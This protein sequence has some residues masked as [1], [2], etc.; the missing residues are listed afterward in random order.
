MKLTLKGKAIEG[1]AE[2]DGFLK[3]IV[4]DSFSWGARIDDRI[5]EKSKGKSAKNFKGDSIRI[6]KF[7]DGASTNLFG[8]MDTS[9]ESHSAADIDKFKNDNVAVISMAT[10]SNRGP[11]GGGPKKILEMTL[12]G[13]AIRE[14]ATSGSGSGLSMELGEDLQ[15]SF[16][17]MKLDYFPADTTTYT[18]G[19][20][21]SFTMQDKSAR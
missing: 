15:L 10:Y 21:I 9:A 17:E 2:V 13:C 20:A 12:R 3:Y 8:A 6:S 5:A 7:L 19:A 4:L 1:D 14:I 16:E 11:D 18:R